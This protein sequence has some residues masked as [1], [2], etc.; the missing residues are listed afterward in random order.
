[1][2]FVNSF[3]FRTLA[4]FAAAA[5]VGC[6]HQPAAAPDAQANQQHPDA[7]PNQQ[8]PDAQ[9]NQQQ[10]GLPHLAAGCLAV[11]QEATYVELSPKGDLCRCWAPNAFQYT[12]AFPDT[13]DKLSYSRSRWSTGMQNV[14][15]C[16]SEGRAWEPSGD[17]EQIV[18]LD[19]SAPP[20]GASDRSAADHSAMPTKLPESVF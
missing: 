6:A 16:Q 2:S 11:C 1:M 15:R 8:H 7:Q 13:R 10:S 4:A 5:A 9:A 12:F 17:R 20:P 18:C 14:R 3:S 19:P